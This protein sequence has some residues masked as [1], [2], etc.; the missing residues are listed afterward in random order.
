M[1]QRLRELQRLFGQDPS[2]D[3]FLVLLQEYARAGAQP[4]GD[5]EALKLIVPKSDWHSDFSVSDAEMLQDLG[6]PTGVYFDLEVTM[7][8]RGAR[9]KNLP[10]R[11]RGQI[12]YPRTHQDPTS[13][14]INRQKSKFPSIEQIIEV[15][16]Q[17]MLNKI[18]LTIEVLEN[19]PDSFGEVD[20]IDG[21]DIESFGGD[22]QW[23]NIQRVI[24]ALQIDPEPTLQLMRKFS[25]VKTD[26]KFKN[27]GTSPITT[28]VYRIFVPAT[29]LDQA[30]WPLTVPR[31]LRRERP[32]TSMI[33]WKAPWQF[34][35]IKDDIGMTFSEVVERLDD[36][37]QSVMA[38]VKN[39]GL[40]FLLGM[41]CYYSFRK[42]WFQ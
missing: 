35:E 24:V 34:K 15:F 16:V 9:V 4:Q 39:F 14:A 41:S 29:L 5:I 11:R 18:N 27:T 19:S 38:V 36:R 17:H 26:L 22:V 32:A 33:D 30:Y 25:H 10:R 31:R 2:A 6:Y 3:K 21:L 40:N 23:N 28:A 7:R 42:S 13:A 8:H 37:Q 20:S 1:D 12:N